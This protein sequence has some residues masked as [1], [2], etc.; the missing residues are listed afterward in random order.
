MGWSRKW[1]DIAALYITWRRLIT[2]AV[3]TSVSHVAVPAR[4]TVASCEA[5]ANIRLVLYPTAVGMADSVIAHAEHEGERD[6]REIQRHDVADR[7]HRNAVELGIASR[8]RSSERRWID[9]IVG[10]VRGNVPDC[11]GRYWCERVP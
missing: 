8:R 1:T 4:V 7:P 9:D 10:R 2:D 6:R 11:R 5:P 3:I